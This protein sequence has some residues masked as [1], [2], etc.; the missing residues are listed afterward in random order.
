MAELIVGLDLGQAVDFTALAILERC[1]I[2][3]A[4]PPTG[5]L[6]ADAVAQYGC[7]ALK[8][9]SLG[10]PYTT[11]A[12]AVIELFGRPPLKGSTLVIDATGV[13]RPVVDMV[14][15]S[16]LCGRLV[17]VTITAG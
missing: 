15:K 4:G 2:P 17:P 13:G 5:P 14:R 12:A 8:R 11:I 1:L 10:T 16:G 9:W 6:V 3:Q 7:R